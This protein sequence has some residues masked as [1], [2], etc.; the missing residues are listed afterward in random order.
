[1]CTQGA[2][3]VCVVTHTPSPLPSDPASDPAEGGKDPSD[4]HTLWICV[5]VLFTA[6]HARAL[7]GSWSTGITTNDVWSSTHS[8][9]PFSFFLHRPLCMCRPYC[10]MCTRAYVPAGRTPLR[11]DA[12]HAVNNQGQSACF[13]VPR[14]MLCVELTRPVCGGPGWWRVCP[15][16][17]IYSCHTVWSSHAETHSLFLDLPPLRHTHTVSRAVPREGHHF[18]PTPT[19]YRQSTILKVR[20]LA[21]LSLAPC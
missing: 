14:A 4:D 19:L 7:F 13:A 17:I 21:L 5:I 8:S 10:I 15:I 16:A 11:P 20:A 3:S 9:S 1:V 12:Q 18:D 2:M 6:R